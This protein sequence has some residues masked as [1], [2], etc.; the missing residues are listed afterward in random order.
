MGVAAGKYTG[1]VN[2]EKCYNAPESTSG[3]NNTKQIFHSCPVFSTV[4]FTLTL[5]LLD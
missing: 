4:H 3:E 1:R 5:P 2:V